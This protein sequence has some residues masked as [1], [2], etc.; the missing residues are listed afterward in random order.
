MGRSNAIH[1][2]P[3][4]SL[5]RLAGAINPRSRVPIGGKRI[6]ITGA[7]SGIGR[8]AAMRFAE[9]GA[10]VVLVARRENELEELRDDIVAAGGRAEYRACDI[11]DTADVDKLVQWVIDTFDGIDVLINNAARSIRRPLVDSFDRFHDFERTMSVNYFGAV[12]LTMGL[13]PAM[14]DRKTGHIINVGT[15][16]VAID[17]APRFAA[18]H[19]SKVALAGFGRCIEA[20]LGNRGIYVTAI[21]YPLVSTPMS[22]PTGDFDRLAKLTPEEAATWLVRAVETRPTE[23]VP[24]YAALMRMMGYVAP[25]ALDNF[26]RNRT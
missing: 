12:R 2:E 20:E 7:S 14:L 21:H 24:R 19:S 26:L 9:A 6:L 23:M 4:F 17:T 3:T 11:A 18:Y 13:L 10:E 22:A 5:R 15:W 25:R 1:L 16:T 8:V